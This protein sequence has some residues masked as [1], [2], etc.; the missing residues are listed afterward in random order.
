MVP[1]APSATHTRWARASRNS[2]ARV[3]VAVTGMFVR[4]AIRLL[5]ISSWAPVRERIG[6]PRT[7]LFD[8]VRHSRASP[9]QAFQQAVQ[10]VFVALQPSRRNTFDRLIYNFFRKIPDAAEPRLEFGEAT[11]GP[12]DQRAKIQALNC[13]LPQTP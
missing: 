11:H 6:W 5:R 13:R 4:Y 3:G 10:L 1:M 7:T 2:A 9:H 8:Q 12:I